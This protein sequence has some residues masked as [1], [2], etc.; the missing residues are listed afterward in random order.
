MD[1]VNTGCWRFEELQVWN[2]GSKITLLF[3]SVYSVFTHEQE[4]SDNDSGKHNLVMLN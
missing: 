1:R 3:S 2:C 4:M